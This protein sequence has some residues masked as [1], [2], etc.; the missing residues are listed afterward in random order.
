MPLNKTDRPNCRCARCP[1]YSEC[2][3]K[4]GELLFCLEGKTDCLVDNQGCICPACPV[5]IKHK[6]KNEFYCIEGSEKERS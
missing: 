2:S 5:F 1:S 6:L 4:K 3:S